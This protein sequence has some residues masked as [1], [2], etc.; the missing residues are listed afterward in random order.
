MSFGM[1]VALVAAG[2]LTLAMFA[3]YMRGADRATQRAEALLR[4]HLTPAE[5]VQLNSLGALHVASG[6]TAGRLYAIPP[7]GAVT[8]LQDGKPV[9]R[10]CIRPV[11]LLPGREAV[12]AHKLHIE[13]AEED[14]LRRGNVVW[15]DSHVL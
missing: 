1:T 5:L 3:W 2:M 13:A 6:M 9:M 10:L 14:Y 12:L 7:R 8:V 11:T 15:R 4:D